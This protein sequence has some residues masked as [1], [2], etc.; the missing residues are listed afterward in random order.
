ML[1]R[2]KWLFFSVLISALLTAGGAFFMLNKSLPQ[3]DGTVQSDSLTKPVR[4]QRDTLGQAIIKAENLP[5]AA[6]ALGVAHGQDRFF[7]MDLQRRV[8][9]GELSVWLGDMALNADKKARFHQFRQRAKTI[10]NQLPEP[11][12][13]LLNRYAS[14]VNQAIRA[15][16][17]KPFEYWLTGFDIQPWTPE[18]SIL[19]VFSMYMDLQAGQVELDLARTAVA[20]HF[21]TPML[22]FIQ[23]ATQYQAALDGSTLPYRINEIPVL[24]KS[25]TA[26]WNGQPPPDLGSNNWAVSGALTDTRD[27]ML[28][29]DMHL[30]LRVPAIWYRT[31]INYTRQGKPV[32]MTG[33][34]LPGLPGIVV[35]TNGAIAWGF[36]NANLDNVDWIKLDDDATTW[37]LSDPIQS[38]DGQHDFSITMSDYGPVRTMNDHQYALRWVAHMPYAVNLTITDLD[39]AQRTADAVEL[40]HQI[41]IP[42]QNMVIVDSHGQLAWT[43]G[44]AVAARPLPSTTAISE[45]EVSALWQHHEPSLPVVMNPSSQRLWTANARVISIEQ[46]SR[47]GDGGYAVGARGQQIRD[48]LFDYEEFDEARFY[49][50]QLDN[51]ARF[52]MPW[53]NLLSQTLAQQTA[54]YGDDLEYLKNW[55]ACA[56]A[57]S[58]GYTL[59]RAFRREVTNRLLDP[60]TSTVRKQGVSPAG[61]LRQTEGAIWAILQQQPYSWLPEQYENWQAFL[62]SAYQQARQQLMSDHNTQSLGALAWGKVNA[63]EIKHPFAANVPLIG[64]LLNMQKAPGFGDSFMPAVQQSEFGASQRLFVRPGQLNKAILTL[65]GGQSGHPLSQY[66]RAGFNDYTD[67]RQT[68][69]LPGNIEHTLTLEPAR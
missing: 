10:L 36:T 8:A 60:I 17:T 59:V 20:E 38:R 2:F 64:G 21:G 45:T 63:L 61:L 55:Q 34:S 27:A 3:L 53:H 19:V 47:F 35:G 52:L 9:A 15:L 62:V 11:Q 66:Y 51:E 7:Q 25:A 6:F 44:G 23:S 40:A 65:P 13:N 31:Q 28:A 39:L 1:R 37:Q 43:P 68:P 16:G 18:D 67:N 29:N 5:D 24:S 4:L 22:D 14:G 30:G 46:L 69:L 50:I 32:Q 12:K 58:V 42:V 57:D 54:Q 41:R 33:V 56:C 48:R 49:A 26:Q